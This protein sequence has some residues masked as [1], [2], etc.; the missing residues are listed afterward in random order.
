[1]SIHGALKCEKCIVVKLLNYLS[2]L[3]VVQ[4]RHDQGRS[5]NA[6]FHDVQDEEHTARRHQINQ[7]QS[8]IRPAMSVARKRREEESFR[9]PWRLI[10]RSRLE[11][12]LEALVKV[13]KGSEVPALVLADANVMDC[14]HVLFCA[15]LLYHFLCPSCTCGISFL[16]DTCPLRD[17]R[18]RIRIRRL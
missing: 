10:Q 16:V 13:S 6:L 9:S 18:M 12:G 7:S 3:D 15:Q 11:R 4:A 8:N 1:M 5:S 14:S 2:L 17:N